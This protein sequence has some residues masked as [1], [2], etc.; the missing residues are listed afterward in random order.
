MSVNFWIFPARSVR[1]LCLSLSILYKNIISLCDLFICSS[2]VSEYS[3]IAM[4]FSLVSFSRSLFVAS[5]DL[6][7]SS[8]IASSIVFLALSICFSTRIFNSSSLRAAI[9]SISFGDNL[10]FTKKLPIKKITPVTTSVISNPVISTSIFSHQNFH[11]DIFLLLYFFR[12]FYFSFLI[13][14]QNNYSV[15]RL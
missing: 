2:T 4:I 8:S 3:F 7:V 9:L 10:S 13:D 11:F 12:P 5:L 15:P 6:S 14:F 1:S